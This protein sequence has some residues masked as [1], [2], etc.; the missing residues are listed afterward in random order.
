MK[1]GSF[2]VT[3]FTLLFIGCNVVFFQSCKK[4]K[5]V[6]CLNGGTESNGV[7][8]C[9][10]GFSGTDCSTV[11]P[12]PFVGGWQAKDTITRTLPVYYTETASYVLLIE[13]GTT[14]SSLKLVNFHNKNITVTAIFSGNTISIPS[15]IGWDS[16]STLSG[17]GTIVANSLDLNLNYTYHDSWVLHVKAS[18]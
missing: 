15:Q 7:C 10:T 1:K 14:S 12:S 8:N 11:T 13:Q 16:G 6:T 4:E 9:P 5:T 2:L 18:K 3:L 17:S